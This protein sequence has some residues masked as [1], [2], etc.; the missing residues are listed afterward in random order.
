LIPSEYSKTPLKT[1]AKGRF[2]HR[3]TDLAGIVQLPLQ[4]PGSG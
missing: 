2:Q 4:A 1:I 3:L